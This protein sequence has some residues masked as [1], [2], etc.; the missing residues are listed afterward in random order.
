[1]EASGKR[2]I[3]Y[4]SRSDSLRIWHLSDLHYLSKGCAVCE[5]RKD[6]RTIA[7]DPFSFWLGGGDYCLPATA[8]VLTREGFVRITDVP[9]GAEVLAYR[10]GATFWDTVEDRYCAGDQPMIRLHNQTFDMTCT[11]QHKCRD[12]A[13]GCR[14]SSS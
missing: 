14:A 5:I 12:A 2:L 13:A 10:D 1:M 6:I 7:D 8:E 3:Q 9:R 4:P 11:P